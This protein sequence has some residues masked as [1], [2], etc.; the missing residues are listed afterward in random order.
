M[1]SPG[2]Q[3]SGVPAPAAKW[4]FAVPRRGVSA[5]AGR[6]PEPVTATLAVAFEPSAHRPRGGQPGACYNNVLHSVDI[7]PIIKQRASGNACAG[8]GMAAAANHPLRW[9]PTRLICLVATLLAVEG[10]AQNKTTVSP[11]P[12]PRV[13]VVAP[14]LNLS[15]SR[16]FDALKVTDLIASEFLSFP[17][18]AVIPVN[19]VL[20]ELARRGKASVETPEDALDLAQAFNADAA[21][22]VAV[23]EYDPYDP[24]VIGLVMQ[25]YSA[26]PSSPAADRE[27]APRPRT[28]LQVDAQLSAAEAPGPRWQVQRVFNAADEH[29]VKDIRSF[30]S[31][32]DGDGSPY[33][34]R[35]YTKSQELYVR[36]CGWA[37]IRTMLNLDADGQMA[38]EPD[39][40]E[41]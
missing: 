12:S 32:R 19:R 22:V 23:T 7:R 25:W 15:G 24:P 41:S 31:K 2:S 11:L 13:L 3:M 5:L 14:V 40:A 33:G 4:N 30:A 36:Y 37:L 38:V 21:I 29:L 8:A 20:A 27:S 9:S 28:G 34:W 16:D 1:C 39:E 26:V 17:G 10:C 35:R 6:G 18:I